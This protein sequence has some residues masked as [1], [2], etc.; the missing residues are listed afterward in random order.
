MWKVIFWFKIPKLPEEREALKKVLG[1]K[2][3]KWKSLVSCREMN[4][5]WEE[6][7]KEDKKSDNE[8]IMGKNLLPYRMEK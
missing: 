7:R 4:Q 2:K 1:N 3:E 6:I 8:D 5:P